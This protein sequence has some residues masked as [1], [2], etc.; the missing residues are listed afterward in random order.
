M[1]KLLAA[2]CGL[3]LSAAAAQAAPVYT[4]TFDAAL[5]SEWTGVKTLAAVGGYSGYGF[6]GSFL[7][8][9]ASGSTATPSTLTLGGFTA[10]Q[11][12][13]LSFDLATIDSWD[14]SVNYG[15][16]AGNDWFNVAVNGTTVFSLSAAQ[17]SGFGNEVIPTSAM[18]SSPAGINLYGNSGWADAAYKVSFTL[19]G[20]TETSQISFFASGTGW[21]GGSDESW[22]IDNLSVEADAAPPPVPLPA[23]APLLLGGLAAAGAF[24]RRRKQG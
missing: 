12:A 17:V 3:M 4:N 1:N 7:N 20:L 10:G 22:A 6:S 9:T 8:N 11:S 15:W 14:G 18:A 23:T 21:Q 13:V 24:L 16:N 2:A 19:T 5:G